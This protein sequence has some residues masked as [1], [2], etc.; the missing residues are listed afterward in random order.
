MH[1]CCVLCNDDVI[2]IVSPTSVGNVDG[3]CRG[4]LTSPLLSTPHTSH[5][6]P[7]LHRTTTTSLPQR[8]KA[9]AVV[10]GKNGGGDHM[11]SVAMVATPGET[12]VSF[13]CTGM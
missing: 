8:P 11:I 9:A 10:S 3:G 13:Q 5:S 7:P 6:S 2:T 1:Y 12:P 4:Y